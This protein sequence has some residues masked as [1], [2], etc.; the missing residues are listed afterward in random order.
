MLRSSFK[1][2]WLVFSQCLPRTHTEL[3]GSLPVPLRFSD[4]TFP[5]SCNARIARIISPFHSGYY[6]TPHHCRPAVRVLS[7]YRW[8]LLAL[9]VIFSLR[10]WTDAKPLVFDATLHAIGYTPPLAHSI[11]L[12]P[13]P[14]IADLLL[15]HWSLVVPS[16][17]VG[18][19]LLTVAL[20][21]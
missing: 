17:A 11:S 6:L 12:L 16:F 13:H 20:P 9:I 14:C 2:R 19:L 21:D 4:L 10:A 5:G 15:Q 8:A 18:S 7:R 3:L 1:C